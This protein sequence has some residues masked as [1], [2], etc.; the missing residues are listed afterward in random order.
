MSQPTCFIM[1]NGLKATLHHPKSPELR[2]IVINCTN[3]SQKTLKFIL[4]SMSMFAVEIDIENE[5]IYVIYLATV[6]HPPEDT[7][8]KLKENTKAGLEENYGIIYDKNVYPFT[9]RANAALID[10][11]T[12]KIKPL[13]AP[14]LLEKRATH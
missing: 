10:A 8:Q 14:L 1:E 2:S 7:M 9:F 6:D 5:K 4:G 13:L 3:R 12:H 11:L